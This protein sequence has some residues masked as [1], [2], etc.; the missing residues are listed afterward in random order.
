MIENKYGEF[1]VWQS[2]SEKELRVSYD[3]WNELEWLDESQPTLPTDLQKEAERLYP[4]ENLGRKAEGTYDGIQGLLQQ[5]YLTAASHFQERV[6][7][8]EKLSEWVDER[9]KTFQS[10][11]AL[12]RNNKAW[13]AKLSFIKELKV[14][15]ENCGLTKHDL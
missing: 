15:L 10:E 9:E 7:G 2:R 6:K 3:H 5:A 11:A 12:H 8:I 1:W 13:N 4:Y 14:M